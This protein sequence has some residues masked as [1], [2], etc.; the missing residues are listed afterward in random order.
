MSRTIVSMI[1]CVI[2]TGCNGGKYENVHYAEKFRFTRGF[3]KNCL[4][5]IKTDNYTGTL[6]CEKDGSK[7]S[8]LDHAF[9]TDEYRTNCEDMDKNGAVEE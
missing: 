7:A 2:A 1:L 4:F 5:V 6:Y 8:A 3:Y 9:V